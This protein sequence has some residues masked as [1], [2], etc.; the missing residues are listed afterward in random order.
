MRDAILT[1]RVFPVPATVAIPKGAD[2]FEFDRTKND[3]RRVRVTT[4]AYTAKADCTE[5]VRK[6]PAG[7]P[8]GPMVRLISPESMAGLRVRATQVTVTEA[9]GGDCAAQI[10][11]AV[12]PLK[13]DIAERDAYIKAVRAIPV[14]DAPR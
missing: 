5:L 10:A 12:A 9:P 14:P 3:L 8:S 4:K 6:I 2:V 11:A 7:A 1:D 13:E